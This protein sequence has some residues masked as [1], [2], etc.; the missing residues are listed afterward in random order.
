MMDNS[1]LQNLLNDLLTGQL[2]EAGRQR[3]SVLLE[4]SSSQDLLS[5]MLEEQLVNN[6][7]A[8]EASLPETEKQFLAQ[9]LLKSG[10]S[11]QPAPAIPPVRRIHPLRKWGWAAAII[12]VCGTAAYLWT[13]SR[14]TAGTTARD[15]HSGPA[16]I[17]PGGERAVLTLGD[18]SRITL[19]TVA[20]GQLADQGG[21][22]VIKLSDG[23][24]SY[25]IQP[26][27]S[28]EPVWNTMSTP[29]GG[30]YQVTLPDGT[31]VWLNASSS[32]SFPTAFTGAHRIVKIAGEVYM[33]VAKN[34][35]Q[36]FIVNVTAGPSVE[37]L[38]TSFNIN[39]YAN[40]E[41]TRT[42]LLEGSIKVSSEGRQLILRP[43]QQA[44]TDAVNPSG[45][46]LR[47]IPEP[48]LE[49]AIAWKNGLFNF[50]GSD[51]RAV[52]RQLERWYDIT[53]K[54][55][56]AVPSLVFKGE[57]NRGVKLSTILNWFAELGIQTRLE[58][59]TLIIL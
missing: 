22:K 39:S 19:D 15:P 34:S 16:D 10:I 50:N 57:M 44:A 1:E 32:L 6:E 52:T 9:V 18:G 43:G 58:G 38:G 45:R 36:P 40:E 17:L 27:T 20:N 49:K 11:G 5:Q 3:L 55:E 28:R 37:V 31:R 26:A 24:L 25:T 13:A 33:E 8:L 29:R 2:T 14:Q 21:V 42:T 47:L 30:Q 53:V 35:Q 59:K 46:G 54:Y 12:L 23:Q 56:A 51:L 7:F 48:D 41:S 4:E